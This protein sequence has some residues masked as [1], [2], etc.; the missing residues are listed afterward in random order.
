MLLPSSARSS[1]RGQ[2]GVAILVALAV[3][4]FASYG[5]AASFLW[6]NQR[7]LIFTPSRAGSRTPADLHLAYE[8]VELQVTGSKDSFLHGWW[9]PS[10]E[11]AAPTLLYLHGSDLNIGANLVRVAL[12]HRMGFSV[13]IVDYRGYGE[14]SGHAPTEASVYADA[15]TMWDY[16]IHERQVDPRQTFIYGHSLGAAVAIDLASRH[17]DAAGLIV[18]SAFTSIGDVAALRYWMFPADWID[19]LLTERFDSLARIGQLRVPV[20]FIHGTA[21]AEVPCSMS[22]QLY[23]AAREPKWLILIPGGGHEDDD[24]VGGSRYTQAVLDFARANQRGR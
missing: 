1:S 11:G 22:E 7:K 6:A 24:T 14:S 5:G 20:L 23:A 4:L 10:A 13:L 17:P 21:D 16:L 12:F 9:L 2:R 15:E 8:D 19:R 18:E 3:L